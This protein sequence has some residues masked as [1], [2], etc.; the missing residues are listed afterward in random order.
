MTRIAGSTYTCTY[1]STYVYVRTYVCMWVCMYVY[2]CVW[3]YVCVYVCFTRRVRPIHA[4]RTER[5]FSGVAHVCGR[6]VLW[7][8]PSSDNSQVTSH[9]LDYH[10]VSPP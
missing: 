3:V 9:R 5:H 7:G 1:E 4:G 8:L 10:N 2:V 6:S